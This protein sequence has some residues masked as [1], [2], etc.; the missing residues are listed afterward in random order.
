M[1][2]YRDREVPSSLA[3]SLTFI[4]EKL[5]RFRTS[6]FDQSVYLL[7]LHRLL[8]TRMLRTPI[9]CL[10][11]GFRFLL[12]AQSAPA[13]APTG[14]SLACDIRVCTWIGDYISGHAAPE[15]C[16][17]QACSACKGCYKSSEQVPEIYLDYSPLGSGGVK[18]S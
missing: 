4:F 3:F 10:L 16:D 17:N 1:D 12:I 6:Y 11:F 2:R 7:K 5:R 15:T 9:K 14:T 13:P 18:G 8:L